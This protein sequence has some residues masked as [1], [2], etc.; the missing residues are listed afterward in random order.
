MPYILKK[1]LLIQ[2]DSAPR[3]Q[4]TNRFSQGLP[5]ILCQSQKETKKNAFRI[6]LKELKRVCRVLPPVIELI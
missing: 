6:F 4:K 2:R 1:F 5:E 3:R